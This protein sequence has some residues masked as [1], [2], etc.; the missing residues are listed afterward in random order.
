MD[1]DAA[2]SDGS[3]L[4]V[5]TTKTVCTNVKKCSVFIQVLVIN[6]VGYKLRTLFKFCNRYSVNLLLVTS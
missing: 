4:R 5:G 1:P 2:R 6:T 3:T